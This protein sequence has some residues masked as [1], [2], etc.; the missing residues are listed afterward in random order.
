MSWLVPLLSVILVLGSF[1]LYR[2][3]AELLLVEAAGKDAQITQAQ[4]KIAALEA[5]QDGQ[6]QKE[7][8]DDQAEA[9]DVLESGDS[10]R[11]IGFLRGSVH[12]KDP[13][14]SGGGSGPGV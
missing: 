2:Y 6:R 14:G 1:L 9:K 12:H 5:A 8:A 10:S 7:H 11:A 3:R 13:N 4:D